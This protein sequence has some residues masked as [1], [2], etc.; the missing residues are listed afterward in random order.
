MIYFEYVLIKGINDDR[1]SAEALARL[2]RKAGARI[3]VIG[4]NNTSG[5]YKRPNQAAIETFAKLLNERGVTATVRSSRG[6][7]IMA[8]CGQLAMS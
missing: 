6:A 5:N 7:D 3:N 4:Y 2:A 1:P 8:A